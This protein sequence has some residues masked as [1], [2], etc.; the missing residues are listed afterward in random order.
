[1]KRI[2]IFHHP[3]SGKCRRIARVHKFF[4]LLGRVRISAAIPLTGPLQPGEIAVRDA[5]SGETLQ[6]VRA[7]RL[8]AGSIPAYLPLLPLPYLP[9]VEHRL[10]RSVRPC[11]DE[12]CAVPVR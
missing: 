5:C 11:E 6:G 3:D 10:E 2:T 8:I 9:A 4:D 1:M 7:V 12:S